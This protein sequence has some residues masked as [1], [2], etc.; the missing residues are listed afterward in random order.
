MQEADRKRAD[1]EW[2]QLNK[3]IEELEGK[4]AIKDSGSFFFDAK[5]DGKR[6]KIMARYNDTNKKEALTK[7]ERKKKNKIDELTIYFN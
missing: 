1:R 7:I 6:V 4:L 2:A 3:R 5:V